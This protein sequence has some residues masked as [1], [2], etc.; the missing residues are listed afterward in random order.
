MDRRVI[1]RGVYGK[2]MIQLPAGMLKRTHRL[3]ATGLTYLI[4]VKQPQH[5]GV[6]AVRNSFGLLRAPKRLAKIIAES[7]ELSVWNT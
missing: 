5:S 7:P 4:L 1:L 3:G 2:G 6:D